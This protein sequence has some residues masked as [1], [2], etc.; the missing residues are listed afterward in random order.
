MHTVLRGVL[1]NRSRYK[2]KSDILYN[3]ILDR[4]KFATIYGT[5]NKLK[6]QQHV[7]TFT[8]TIYKL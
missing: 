7:T 3:Y 4:E 1:L 8:G 6:R 2:I 5:S